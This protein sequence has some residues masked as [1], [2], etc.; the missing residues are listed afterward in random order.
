MKPNKLI[1]YYK[2]SLSYE[3]EGTMEMLN[4]LFHIVHLATEF[5][6]G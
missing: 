6:R 2:I 3:L 1:G 4:T 5:M